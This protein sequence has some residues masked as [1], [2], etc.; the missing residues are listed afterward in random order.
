[1]RSKKVESPLI[2]K[3]MVHQSSNQKLIITEK[4]DGQRKVLKLHY[5]AISLT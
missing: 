5:K 2:I 3:K 4:K 1:M